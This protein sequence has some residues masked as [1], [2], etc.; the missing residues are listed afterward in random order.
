MRDGQ[1]TLLV[2]HVESNPEIGSLARLRRWPLGNA[3]LCKTNV[4]LFRYSYIAYLRFILT[5]SLAQT[6]TTY[7]IPWSAPLW[8]FLVNVPVNVRL[9]AYSTVRTVL[10]S[11]NQSRLTVNWNMAHAHVMTQQSWLD[12]FQSRWVCLSSL[13]ARTQTCEFSHSFLDNFLTI[14]ILNQLTIHV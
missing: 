8:L 3:R 5:R 4:A 1:R 12:S 7:L 9:S 14:S 2:C 13:L 10:Y 6:S 11:T